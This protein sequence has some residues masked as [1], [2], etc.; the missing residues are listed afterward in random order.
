MRLIAAVTAAA[1]LL[2]YLTLRDVMASTPECRAQARLIEA[3]ASLP[4]EA[5][6][7]ARLRALTVHSPS[8]REAVMRAYAWVEAGLSVDAAWRQCGGI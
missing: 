7:D 1:L 3:I 4:P 2:L 6:Q 8:Q 5:R